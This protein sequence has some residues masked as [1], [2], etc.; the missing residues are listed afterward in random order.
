MS[1]ACRYAVRA[2]SAAQLVKPWIRRPKHA[3]LLSDL[4]IVHLRVFRTTRH[5]MYV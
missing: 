3:A 5:A 1:G 4:D 2:T